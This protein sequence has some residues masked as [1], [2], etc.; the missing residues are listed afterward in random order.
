[1]TETEI[2]ETTEKKQRAEV[3]VRGQLLTSLNEAVSQ[4]DVLARKLGRYL[5]H[6]T[7]ALTAEF[8]DA[9]AAGQMLRTLVPL[10]EGLPSDYQLPRGRSADPNRP[11]TTGPEPFEVGDIVFCASWAQGRLSEK[12]RGIGRALV[13]VELT[14]EGRHAQVIVADAD[15]PEGR[16]SSVYPGHLFREGENEPKQQVVLRKGDGASA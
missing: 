2:T 11:K 5:R 8:A 1:M 7:R 12:L 13:V 14:G 15:N 10:I 9:T 16:S 6:P 3:D 4:V